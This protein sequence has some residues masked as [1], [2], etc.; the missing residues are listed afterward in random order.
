MNAKIGSAEIISRG[1]L[2]AYFTPNDYFPCWYLL[3][4]SQISNDIKR[5]FILHCFLL[6]IRCQE[7]QIFS[8]EIAHKV[9][10]WHVMQP[11]LKLLLLADIRLIL[12]PMVH[13]FWEE[14]NKRES[15]QLTDPYTKWAHGLCLGYIPLTSK[16]AKHAR[17]CE[18]G[19]VTLSRRHF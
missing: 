5:K 17:F 8:I 4:T 3:Q 14:N 15:K 19:I 9:V 1:R 2:H 16:F 11:K 18:P 7:S 12:F 13:F 10:A 6:L